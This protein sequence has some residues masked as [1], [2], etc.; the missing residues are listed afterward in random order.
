M[1]ITIAVT[2]PHILPIVES[3]TVPLVFEVGDLALNNLDKVVK[4]DGKQVPL[5]E[6]QYA[7]LY[8]LARHAY[9]GMRHP[10]PKQAL[11][12]EVYGTNPPKSNSLDVRLWEVRA[13][14]KNA[15]SPLIIQNV[16]KLG[17]KLVVPN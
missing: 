3:R 15:G 13:A 17:F 1:N 10:M 14:L 9:K 2:R 6:L 4:K 12:H 7:L 8:A 16:Y 5:G 11:L